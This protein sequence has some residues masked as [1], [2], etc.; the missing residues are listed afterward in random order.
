MEDDTSAME[1]T[2]GFWWQAESRY[3]RV[4]IGLGLQLGGS[5]AILCIEECVCYLAFV[6][7]FATSAALVEV[8]ARLSAVLIPSFCQLFLIFAGYDSFIC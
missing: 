7:Y 1:E 4:R 2:F 3:I 8:C 5:T 6:S